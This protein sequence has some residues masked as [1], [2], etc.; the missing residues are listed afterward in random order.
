MSYVNL[1]ATVNRGQP[2]QMNDGVL[3]TVR[4]TNRGDFG[5]T[6]YLSARQA[7][8]LEGA[9][10]VANNPTPGTPVLSLAAADGYN[11]LEGFL[12]IYNGNGSGTGKRIIL[13]RLS[14]QVGVAGASGTNTEYASYKDNVSRY[15]SGGAEITP[16]CLSRGDAETVGATVHAGALVTAAANDAQLIQSG[17]IRTVIAV[18]GDQ[19]HF[20]FSG[21]GGYAPAG[22]AQEGT[23]QLE[24]VIPHHPVI[25]D[26]GECFHFSIFGASQATAAQYEFSV[27]WYER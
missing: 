18:A 5:M 9:Y 21:H 14:L 12:T 20:D 10:F 3:G 8:A 6:P 4:C 24:K 11:A 1:K 17:N 19:Y 13:D 26:P 16:V 15:A 2:S 7:L 25:L 22:V 23:A 27:G